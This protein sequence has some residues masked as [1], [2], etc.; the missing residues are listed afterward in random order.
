MEITR[1]LLDHGYRWSG[2][3]EQL[4]DIVDNGAL[5]GRTWLLSA[6]SASRPEVVLLDSQGQPVADQPEPAPPARYVYSLVRGDDGRW[7]IGEVQYLAP[8]S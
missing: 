8:A 7:R 2:P 4:T 6:V 5:D 3:T 1:A